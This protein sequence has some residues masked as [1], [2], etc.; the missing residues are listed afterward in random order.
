MGKCLKKK[1]KKKKK[2]KEKKK[3]KKNKK[4]KKK[5]KKK[6]QIKKTKLSLQ[7]FFMVNF[8]RVNRP[9][10]IWKGRRFETILKLDR[11][12]R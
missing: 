8:D 11:D 10:D 9:I 7:L 1:K 12:L 6:K 5:K 2:K 4:K 3:K